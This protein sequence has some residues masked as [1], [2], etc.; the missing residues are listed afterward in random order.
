M[1]GLAFLCAFSVVHVV[2]AQ[3]PVPIA[4][5]MTIEPLQPVEVG[6]PVIIAAQ[7]SLVGSESSEALNN[8]GIELLIDGVRERVA[9]TDA[10]GKV[11]FRLQRE[12]P[13]GTYNIQ[14]VYSG[15]RTLLPSQASTTLTINPAAPVGLPILRRDR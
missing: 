4:T 1:L 11:T 10:A 15:S 5:K 2:Q 9:L 7:L 6:K 3:E 8:E 14:I 12:L 13:P